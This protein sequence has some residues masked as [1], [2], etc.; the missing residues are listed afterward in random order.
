MFPEA[1][2]SLDRVG[3]PS[4]ISKEQDNNFMELEVQYRGA[5]SE[6]VSLGSKSKDNLL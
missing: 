2:Q 3:E 6:E 1:S 5:G 4:H